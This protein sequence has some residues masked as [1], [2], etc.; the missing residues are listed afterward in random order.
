[1]DIFNKSKSK[2]NSSSK[3]EEPLD[4]LLVAGH[5]TMIDETH[6]VPSNSVYIY[7]VHCGFSAVGKKVE[8]EFFK[9]RIP[10]NSAYL[11]SWILN[12][13][14]NKLGSANI[15]VKRPNEEYY[16]S[17][18][19]FILD[20]RYINK[21]QEYELIDECDTIT[22]Q[23][24]G[25]Y[26]Y[27][28]IKSRENDHNPNE[29]TVLSLAYMNEKGKMKMLA[30]DYDL[31]TYK[32][33][34]KKLLKKHP[35]TKP[36]YIITKEDIIDIYEDSIYPTVEDLE[37]LFDDDS[38]HMRYT[39]F[40]ES[41]SMYEK[42]VSECFESYKNKII[43]VPSCRANDEISK[44]RM[45]RIQSD[46]LGDAEGR[47][48]LNKDTK[49]FSSSSKSSSNNSRRSSSLTKQKRSSNNSTRRKK[50]SS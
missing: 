40:R 37:L 33:S 35:D 42:K 20:F 22:I 47:L 29:N 32:G 2:R 12:T 31:R 14:N 23:K 5:G 34:V 30:Y 48:I 46:S 28:G 25:I 8:R 17:T 6:D 13:T 19:D 7:D 18:I 4:I 9:K 38:D 16:D 50:K 41:I 11:S 10:D 26:S 43:A 49:Y 27:N 36:F 45:M 39:D 24:S 21:K 3:E 15:M 44:R 1:M